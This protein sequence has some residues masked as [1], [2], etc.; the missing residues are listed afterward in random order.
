MEI[1]FN[2]A[3]EFLIALEAGKIELP[4]FVALH[5]YE[6]KQGAVSNYLLNLGVH[7]GRTL[8]R[9]LVM[10][11]FLSINDYDIPANLQYVAQEAYD[12]VHHSLMSN[13]DKNIDN[14]TPMSRIK[15]EEYDHPSA[16]IKV[17]KQT[18]VIYLTGMIVSKK[19]LVEGE[20]KERQSKDKTKVKNIL[21]KN[22]SSNN[23]RQFFI[24]KI[25]SIKINGKHMTIEG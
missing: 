1:K 5:N 12:E 25:T 17:H 14:H 3:F 19:V 4:Q 2:N 24:H 8:E 15:I 13:T 10:F 6:N 7:Y 21:T 22:F 20:Y 11:N 9:D 16:N 23:Y 18:G